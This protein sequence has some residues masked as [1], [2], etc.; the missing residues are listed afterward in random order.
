MSGFKVIVLTLLVGG[1]AAL[2]GQTVLFHL[3]DVLIATILVSGVFSILSVRG[4]RLRRTLRQ[5]R[6][7]VGGVVE[8]RLD[9]QTR[10][11]LPRVW[12]ELVDRGTLP[13]YQG[14]RV[15]DLGLGGRRT[16]SA[17]AACRRRGLYT[18]GPATISGTDPFGL[19][20]V[21]RKIGPTRS[22]L[23]YP[24]T[25]DLAGIILP[26]GQLLGGDRRRRGWHQTTTHV[27]GVRDYAPGDPVRHIH[28]RS[29]AHANRLMVK[30]FDAEPVA[31]VWIFLDLEAAVQRGEDDESTEEYGVTIAASLAKHFLT[32]GRA[33]GLTAIAAE[34]RIIPPDR[35][36]RQLVK[37]LEELA[38]IH[39][40][41]QTPIAE[42]LASESDRCTRNAAIVVITPSLDDRWPGVLRQLHERGIDGAAVVLEASTFGDAEASLLLVGVLATCAI[43]SVLVKRGDNLS[44]VL[45]AAPGRGLASPAGLA[46]RG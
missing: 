4:I 25:V 46:G 2:S 1:F 14:G 32:Q 8:Q 36:Q 11:P 9:L 22:I 7:Q 34:H 5:D 44:Q 13:G 43:P 30:E 40:D 26:A 35:G 15:V 27:A 19:F 12:L 31:D 28:W 16:W 42:V 10:F 37:L 18:L 41:G 6:A 20:R 23:V 21:T 39:A 17:D 29:T 24:A 45:S 38:V 3:T 33:V